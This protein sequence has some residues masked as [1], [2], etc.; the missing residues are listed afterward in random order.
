MP[1]LALDHDERDPF[2]G[3]LDRVRMPELMRRES[4][5]HAGDGGRARELL[6]GRGCLPMATCGRPM[7]HAQQRTNRQPGADLKPRVQLLPGPAVHSDFA[8]FA[9]FASA[10]QDRAVLAVEI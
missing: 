1:E 7:D 6:A 9:V 5:P 2:V 4:A 10:D 8:A 3:H